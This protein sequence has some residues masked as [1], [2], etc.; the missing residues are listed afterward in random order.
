MHSCTF[1]T[2]IVISSFVWAPAKCF[3]VDLLC[4]SIWRYLCRSV[5]GE[6][7][8]QS[9]FVKSAHRSATWW[10]KRIQYLFWC[11]FLPARFFFGYPMLESSS[12]MQTTRY[13]CALCGIYR[14]VLFLLGNITIL[15]CL[16]V[17][18]QTSSTQPCFDYYQSQN[19]SKKEKMNVVHSIPTLF[20]CLLSIASFKM[21]PKK[22]DLSDVVLLNNYQHLEWVSH[23]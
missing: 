2:F 7:G 11:V 14:T 8:F 1:W 21:P 20:K 6:A 15:S 9:S 12:A 17:W 18:R 22:E 4:L 13:C 3:S 10:R 5:W 23:S 19:S 16:V